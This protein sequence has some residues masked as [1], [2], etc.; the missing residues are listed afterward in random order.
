MRKIKKKKY[1]HKNWNGYSERHLLSG[2]G[3]ILFRTIAIVFTYFTQIVHF[4]NI[5]KESERKIQNRSLSYM[6]KT[7]YTSS[8]NITL[9]VMT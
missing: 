5:F 1:S 9:F 4:I 6:N 7:K 8:A 3:K 2:N